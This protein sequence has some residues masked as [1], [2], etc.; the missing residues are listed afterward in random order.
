MAEYK[1]SKCRPNFRA[2]PRRPQGSWTS[3]Q[4][5]RWLTPQER[6]QVRLQQKILSAYEPH[7]RPPRED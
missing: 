7:W 4:I 3:D 2:K 5:W 1:P 6:R